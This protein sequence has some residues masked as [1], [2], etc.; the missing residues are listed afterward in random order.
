[1]DLSPER[2]HFPLLKLPN[3][4][5]RMIMEKSS[6]RGPNE[7]ALPYYDDL[8]S[9]A[10]V[11]P[12]LSAA[13]T[14]VLYSCICIY[15]DEYHDDGLNARLS[16]STRLVRLHRTLRENVGLR[17][18]CTRFILVQRRNLLQG[19]PVESFSVPVDSSEPHQPS[20]PWPR[21]VA[22]II[23]DCTNWLYNTRVLVISGYDAHGTFIPELG[24]I[25]YRVLSCARMSMP[26]LE[27]IDIL[28]DISYHRDV[29]TLYDIQLALS[30]GCSDLK[31]LMIRQRVRH[32]SHPHGSNALGRLRNSNLRSGFS[33]STLTLVNS[34]DHPDSVRNFVTW[35]KG[36]K[37]FTLRWD[38]TSRFGGRRDPQW[39]IALVGDIL[40]PHRDSIESI[41]LGMMSQPG[42][43]DFD[44]SNF[45]NLETLTMHHRD[46]RG[47]VISTCP[48]LQAAR[49]HDV[50]ITTDNIEEEMFYNA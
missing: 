13:A 46:I 47:I 3:E 33:L 40:K 45:P 18:F 9:L 44:A 34:S 4:V 23:L 22:S 7:V 38:F 21:T 37:H 35:L 24:E 26:R 12:R 30:G 11:C 10:L 32:S 6:E 42:L 29:L 2:D 5:L 48:Q 36:L 25:T 14:E 43:G 17:R 20:T 19:G 16:T 41:K 1:M 31:H 8:L 50:I 28:N 15:A 27:C 49:L 39:T